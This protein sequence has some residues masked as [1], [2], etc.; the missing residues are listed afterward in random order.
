MQ[1]KICH[2]IEEVAMARLPNACRL[3]PHLLAIALFV[4]SRCAPLLGQSSEMA[5]APALDVLSAHYNRV[6]DRIHVKLVNKSQKAATA[7]YI[8]FGIMIDKQVNWA[9]GTG[10]DLLHLVLTSQC[11]Y[12]DTNS[13][14]GDSSWEGAIMP[15]DTYVHSYPTNLEKNQLRDPARSVHAA[16]VGVIWS[17]GRVEVTSTIPWAKTWVIPAINRSLDQRKE[18]AEESA[19][20]VAILNAHPEDADVKHRIGEDIKSLQSLMDDYRRARQAQAP[21]QQ[22]RVDSSFL[23]SGVLN[24]LNNFV[25]SPTPKVSKV[26]FDAYSAVFECQY[27][28]RSAMLHA[29]SSTRPER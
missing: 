14:E 3:P 5:T 25:A 19:K 4:T 13:P 29:M 8:A 21:G 6:T 7:Y 16:V 2:R 26:F 24:N 15:G 20:V 18:D 9:S 28:R 27:K 22:M 10:E 23:V 12:A 17:D 11:R 1:Y